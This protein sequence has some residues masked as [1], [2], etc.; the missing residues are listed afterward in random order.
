MNSPSAS[1]AVFTVASVLSVAAFW[2]I[3]IYFDTYLHLVASILIAP[4]VLLRSGASIALG[5]RMFERYW[6]DDRVKLT[7]FNWA[8]IVL[9]AAVCF[10][11]RAGPLAEASLPAH[12]SFSRAVLPGWLVLHIGAGV[13]VPV[14]GRVKGIALVTKAVALAGLAA[15]ALWAA[16]GALEVAAAP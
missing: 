11:L 3:A 13:S 15:A 10:S 7:K 12:L 5:A 16:A 8:L 4:L 14:G 9:A 1:G 6:N 2:A